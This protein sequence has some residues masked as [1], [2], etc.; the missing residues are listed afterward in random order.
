MEPIY[1]MTT[2]LDGEGEMVDSGCLG[3]LGVPMI[4]NIG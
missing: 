1:N 4:R 3:K 2:I